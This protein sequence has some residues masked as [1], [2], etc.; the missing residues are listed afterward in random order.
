MNPVVETMQILK[1]DEL[2]LFKRAHGWFYGSTASNVVPAKRLYDLYRET[3]TY[4]AC[5]LAFVDTVRRNGGQP[6]V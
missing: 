4:P 1:V 6:A 2:L 5:V 3:K